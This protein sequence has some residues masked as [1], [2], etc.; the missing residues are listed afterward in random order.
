MEKTNL[1][2]SLITAIAIVICGICLPVAVKEYRSLDRTITV[3]GLCE[4]EVKSDKVI[5][6]IQFKNVSNSLSTLTEKIDLDKEKIISFLVK[7]GIDKE[8]ISI[9]APFISDK[10]SQ[11]Y[12]S[13]RE[14]RYYSKSVITVCTQKVDLVLALT[15]KISN[16]LKEGVLLGGENEWD[17]DKAEYKFEAL[18]EIKPEM[19]HEATANARIAAEQFAKDSGSKIGRIKTAS[20][21]SFSIENRDSNTPQIK[22]VRVV[23]SITYCLKH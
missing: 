4:R 23:T 15:S 20:Q 5:W 18:N 17:N 14:Y 9:N 3:K 22:R 21:G 2:T 8:E 10:L 16:L 1:K 13:D 12:N 19:I 7:E 6:P 11:Q